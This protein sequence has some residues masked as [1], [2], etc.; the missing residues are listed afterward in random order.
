MP[1]PP[2]QIP[3]GAQVPPGTHP[4]RAREPETVTLPV[5]V[6]LVFALLVFAGVFFLL[7]DPVETLTALTTVRDW[8]PSAQRA[9]ACA[10]ILPLI[11][12]AAL[13]ARRVMLV[14]PGGA[15]AAPPPERRLGDTAS[16]GVFLGSGGH[17]AEMRAMLAAVDRKR[18]SPRVY[19]Y[20]KGDEMSLEA[21]ADIEGAESEGDKGGGGV[22]SS[23]YSFVCLPRA[24]RVGQGRVSSI[25]STINT[26]LHAL[27]Q[28]FLVPLA[29]DPLRPW[30]D[31]LL[32]N[33]PGTA[34]VLVAVMYIRR[35]SRSSWARR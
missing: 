3:L 35:V 16:L 30:A 27:V 20:C 31:V 14:R 34:V 23:A 11:A 15:A 33:G 22:R 19:V 12:L 24:R 10:A 5:A 1:P 25:F 28:L 8:P 7:L 6:P 9:L 26:F 18:Y 29:N 32:L 4:R 17:T 13:A 2:A 21:V